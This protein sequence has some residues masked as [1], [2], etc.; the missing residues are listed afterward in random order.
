[1]YSPSISRRHA[2]C[3]GAAAVSGL[4][5]SLL[6]AE[7]S[8]TNAVPRALPPAARDLVQATFDGLDATRLW[9]VHTH[10]L[11]TGDAASGCWV[12]PHLD[13]W[14]HPLEATRKRVIL[15]GA[16]VAAGSRHE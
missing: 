14:W 12:N 6:A 8:Q 2:L 16:G 7:P 1:M 15:R 10:L 4:F 5:T 9:D 3:C 13:S 11:G